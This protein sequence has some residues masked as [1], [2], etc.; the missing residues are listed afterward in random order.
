MSS[1]NLSARDVAKRETV[2]IKGQLLLSWNF[3]VRNLTDLSLTILTV[4]EVEPDNLVSLKNLEQGIHRTYSLLSKHLVGDMTK[5]VFIVRQYQIA[6]QLFSILKAYND[7]I[8]RGELASLTYSLR[9]VT[10]HSRTLN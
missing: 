4:R 7:R 6:L 1:R 9:D 5:K 2:S 10:K 3:F 8:D